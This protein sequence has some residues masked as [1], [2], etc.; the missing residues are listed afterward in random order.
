L[1]DWTYPFCVE[2]VAIDFCLTSLPNFVRL[3]YPVLL[4]CLRTYCVPLLYLYYSTDLVWC[5]P[6]F[7]S[8]LNF[9]ARTS[10]AP[11][12]GAESLSDSLLHWASFMSSR[13]FPL[14]FG[15]KS[16]SIV[17]FPLDNVILSYPYKE[18]NSL[19]CTW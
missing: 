18:V 1:S 8:F 6:L 17:S 12:R 16:H 5:Q 7:K 10:C 9:F 13:R 2:L 3:H 15:S 4:P 19:F 14:R 11:E